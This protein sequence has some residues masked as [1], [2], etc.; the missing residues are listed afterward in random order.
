MTAGPWRDLLLVVIGAIFGGVGLAVVFNFRGFTDWHIRKTFQLMRP[1]EAP[2]RRMPAW[3]QALAKP[4][5]ER[6]QRQLKLERG[7]GAVFA[8]L[9]GFLLAVG[10]VV[11]LGRLF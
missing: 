8:V 11:L 1:V 4:L 3:K 7:I 6:I 5:E 9:G 10:V 2:F